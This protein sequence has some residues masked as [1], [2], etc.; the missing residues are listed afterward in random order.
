[1]PNAVQHLIFWIVVV[2]AFAVA[3]TIYLENRPE[4]GDE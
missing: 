2:P 4:E 1:M 3:L